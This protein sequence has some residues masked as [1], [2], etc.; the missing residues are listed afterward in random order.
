MNSS[1]LK[2]GLDRIMGKMLNSIDNY[3]SMN[4]MLNAGQEVVLPEKEGFI[5]DDIH[6]DEGYGNKILL[7]LFGFLY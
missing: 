5:V 4:Q 3:G 6:I 1:S 2:I 7:W